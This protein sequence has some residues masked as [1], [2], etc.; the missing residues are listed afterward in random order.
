MLQHFARGCRAIYFRAAV[1][2]FHLGNARAVNEIAAASFAGKGGGAAYLSLF[3]L[4][5]NWGCGL[6][7]GQ[8]AQGHPPFGAFLMGEVV[9]L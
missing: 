1:R 6:Q 4:G 2:A 5:F 7:A 3:G 9:F 8:A